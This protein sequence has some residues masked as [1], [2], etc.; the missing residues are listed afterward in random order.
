MAVCLQALLG[1]EVE[2]LQRPALRLER[3]DRLSQVHDGA[4][5]ADR[6]P[7]DIVCVLQID[8]DRLGGGVGLVVDLAH[9]HVLVRLECLG[10]VSA[11]IV[12]VAGKATYAVLP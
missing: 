11:C 12:E 1:L 10:A 6:S 4:V 2:E 7:N 5:R 8:D 3:D 9:A